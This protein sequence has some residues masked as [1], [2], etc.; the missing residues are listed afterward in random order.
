MSKE[1]RFKDYF[2]IENIKNYLEGNAKY[3][4]D[5]FVGEPRHLREQRLYRLYMCKDDCLVEG[6]C[7]ECGC[8]VDKKVFNDKSCNKGERFPDIMDNEKWDLFKKENG[9]DGEQL[10]STQDK[11]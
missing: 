2:K 5:K 4:Y 6:E 9:I 10:Q 8:P 7:K 11:S 3:Y 1:I